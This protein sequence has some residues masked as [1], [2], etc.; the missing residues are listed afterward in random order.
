MN[1]NVIKQATVSKIAFLNPYLP[2]GHTQTAE[3]ESTARLIAASRNLSIEVNVFGSCEEIEYFDPDFVV[4]ISFQAPKLTRYPTYGL[5]DVPVSLIKHVPRFVRNVLSYDGYMTISSSVKD[6]LKQLCAANN[7]KIHLAH[8]AFSVQ[9]TQFEP[10][11][12]ATAVAMYIGTNWD[13]ARHADLFKL[14]SS[15]EYLKCYGPE[16]KWANYPKS[17]YSGPIPFDG[18]SVLKAYHQSGI[19]LCIGHPVFDKEGVPSSRTFEISAASA[20]PI[21]SNI[22]LNRHLYGDSAFYLDLNLSTNELAEQLIEYVQWIRTNPS[23]AQEM[24]RHAHDIFSKKLSMEFYLNNLIDMHHKVL[25]ENNHRPAVKTPAAKTI[26]KALSA[27]PKIT[28]ILAV[29]HVDYRSQPI[30]NDLLNQAYENIDIILLAHNA[31]DILN[32]HFMGLDLKKLNISAI[33]YQGI[34]TNAE[35]LSS[36]QNNKSEWFSVLTCDDRIFPNH[37]AALIDN[38]LTRMSDQAAK[39]IAG[40]FSGSVE[41]SHTTHLPER[42]ID[43]HMVV[44]KNR[45]RVGFTDVDTSIPLNAILINFGL[46]D[47]KFFQQVN[48]YDL[49]SE[50]LINSILN[51]GEFLR[52][53]EITCSTNIEN[54]IDMQSLQSKNVELSSQLIE[55]KEIIK[56]KDQEIQNVN[57]LLTGIYSS[58]SWKLVRI[59]KKIKRIFLFRFINLGRSSL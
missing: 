10:V 52:T 57:Q 58:L 12:F 23:L 38:Y 30:L 28:Y 3:I 49:H 2:G 47:S 29:K 9:A 56:N 44:N 42:L 22:D 8:S 37:S 41:F 5:M 34:E 39:V 31:A 59:L 16:S 27:K 18:T 17:L 15:G 36:L 43:E 24:A 54:T 35:I 55:F 21:C 19:G 26:V 48:F 20:L 40:I 50:Q 1:Q 33:P 25:F 4:T 13:G 46:F 7:K 14:L 11:N 45:L 53:C 32:T 6:W 51:R